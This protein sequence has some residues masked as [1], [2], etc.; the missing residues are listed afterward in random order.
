MKGEKNVQ[1]KH[2]K[3]TACAVAAMLGLSCMVYPVHAQE[4]QSS[5]QVDTGG[6]LE[7]D[8]TAVPV[9]ENAEPSDTKPEA[10]PTPETG[11][12]VTVP[13]DQTEGED[14]KEE[15]ISEPVEMEQET[16]PE[17]TEQTKVEAESQ[18]QMETVNMLSSARASAVSYRYYENG[19][20]K[21]DWVTDYTVVTSGMD[22]TWKS[23]W[24]VVDSSVI[25]EKRVT[26]K[27]EVHLI[28]KDNHQLTITKGIEVNASVD[29]GNSN[30]LYIYGQ[31]ESKTMGKLIANSEANDAA[32][33]IGSFSSKN[34]CGTIII[35]GGHVEAHAG[36]CAAG[37]GGAWESASGGYITI[38]GGE[39]IATAK[40]SN[41]DP[42][43]IGGG[44]FGSV[45]SIVINGGIIS[46]MG[47]NK[48][49]GNGAWNSDGSITIN[50]GTI[51]ANGVGNSASVTTTINGG[52]VICENGSVN[53][54]NQS[55]WTGIVIEGNSGKVYAENSNKTFTVDTS[56]VISGDYTLTIPNGITWTI[57]GGVTI[58][59]NG[60]IV[61]ENG[62]AINGVENIINNGI[63]RGLPAP[64]PTVEIEKTTASSITV[65][66]LEN[67]D[68][69]GEA[70]YSLD[71]VNWQTG[72]VL[73]D[74]HSNTAYTV[75]ARYKGNNN[76]YAESDAGKIEN[77]S[78]NTATYT[79]T[80]P[81]ETVEAGNSES[82]AELKP[83]ESF[84]VG[85]GGTA[86][87]KVKKDSGVDNDG[88]LTLTRQNDTGKHTI[89]SALLVNNTAL[90][91][92]NNHVAAFTMDNKTPVSVSFAKPTETNIP[93]G[94]YN[95][96]IIF[97][98]S[99]S[100]Q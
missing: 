34:K 15:I 32:I 53:K 28:L 8:E 98:V 29:G 2:K 68:T 3:L 13:E 57:P 10:T 7:A 19:T 89:T 46:A 52:T 86:T 99:Y 76:G 9:E 93:A 94:T 80:I 79:I 96:T 31:S 59:N 87:V 56:F 85:Y 84:D 71:K 58:T 63:I 37:I 35:N 50:G 23:G 5:G 45:D 74:L 60:T 62:G 12:T 30:S 33:G 83:S 75:Y 95:G 72:N 100:E 44:A 27:G 77:V 43:A 91:N 17:A 66:K 97:E 26:V 81:A 25:I 92:L 1:K 64:T 22:T 21:T 20:W 69:Y 6:F 14:D 16:Q 70:E 36:V 42:A 4:V 40:G 73:T 24:Y 47:C 67:Q 49:I 65:K 39:V 11:E 88:K 90:G 51:T 38:N 54:D 61:I 78:T 55:N 18:E 41:G 48:G 82:K